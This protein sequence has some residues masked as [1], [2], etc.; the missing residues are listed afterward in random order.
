MIRI[1]PARE[2]DAAYV[3]AT[4]LHQVPRF[5]RAVEREELALCVRALLNASRIVVA[6]AEDDPDTLVGWAASIAGVAW[7]VFVARDARRNGIGARLRLEVVRGDDYDPTRSGNTHRRSHD[8]DA[9]L[10][11]GGGDA[12]GLW[13]RH[14]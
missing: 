9:D 4:A 6:C 5:V 8:G 14:S 10:S 13:S 3:A 2:T 1:R 11:R 7:F 12:L